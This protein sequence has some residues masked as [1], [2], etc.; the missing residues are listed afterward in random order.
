[1]VVT[2]VVVVGVGIL[3]VEGADDMRS[4]RVLVQR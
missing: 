3:V 1:V 4:K 2:E